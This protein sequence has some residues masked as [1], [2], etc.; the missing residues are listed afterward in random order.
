VTAPWILAL[1]LV[2]TMVAIFVTV[3][4]LFGTTSVPRLV[5]VGLV[6]A[7]TWVWFDVS[8]APA[9]APLFQ[10]TSVPWLLF[11]VA[12][13]REAV[14]GAVLG[15]LLGLLL[16][17]ARIAGEF[18][19][20]EMGLALAGTLD[21]STGQSTPPIA[22]VFEN[23]GILVF[24]ALDGHHVFFAALHTTFATWPIGG[25]AASLPMQHVV[26]ATASAEEWG[27]MLA[28]P[29]GILLFLT[30]VVLALMARAAPQLNV[31]SVGFSLK[32]GVGLVG[33]VLLM[34]NLVQALITIFGRCSDFVLAPG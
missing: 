5:K 18:V 6:L 22:Q 21:P 30:S 24:F 1:C 10:T 34:P 8:A 32:I 19:A 2:F 25:M 15:Y 20:Q 27:M 28:A 11:A 16:V 33:S 17:P 23:I 13:G 9:T 4:P 7:L 14:L 29:L 31:F 3:L 12:L 26:R